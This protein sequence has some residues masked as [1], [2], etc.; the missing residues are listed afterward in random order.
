MRGAKEILKR[1]K[2]N[3]KMQKVENTK[4]LGTI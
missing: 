4:T 1:N 2:K 3:H